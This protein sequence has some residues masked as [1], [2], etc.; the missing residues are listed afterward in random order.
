MWSP[1]LALA[2]SQGAQFVV[3][4]VQI[5]Q[6]ADGPKSEVGIKADARNAAFGLAAHEPDGL[7]QAPE[8]LGGKFGGDHS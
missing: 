1:V 2:L 7:T 8:L 3:K 5:V 6:A 4:G